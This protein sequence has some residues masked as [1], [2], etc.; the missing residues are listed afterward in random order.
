MIAFPTAPEAFIAY[1]EQ[2]AGRKLSEREKEVTVTWMEG[3]NLSYED[4]LKQDR[5]ALEDSLAKMDELLKRREES[6]AVHEF[7]Q[8][9][10]QW[11]IYAWEQG[12]ERSV[13]IG[14]DT[15]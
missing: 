11:I 7:L 8:A 6:P 4:G 1:Q 10:R 14:E 2:L 9:A 12:A 15:C 13:S 5:A 3:F